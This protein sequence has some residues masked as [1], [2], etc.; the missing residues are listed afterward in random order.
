MPRVPSPE[1]D[2]V[3]YLCARRFPQSIE[4]P[5]YSYLGGS[6]S[7]Q[8]IESTRKWNLQIEEA[9]KKSE[10]HG[11]ELR[12]LDRSELIRLVSVEKNKEINEIL[13]KKEREEKKLS[14]NMPLFT[15]DIEHYAKLRY[16]TIDE[17]IALAYGR[18]PE[19]ATWAKVKPYT[20]ISEFAKTY[21]RA[22]QIAERA[23]GLKEI[24]Q[25]N[26]P[27]FFIS[28]AKRMVFPVPATLE[29]EV[30]K[31]GPIMDWQAYC[32]KLSEQNNELLSRIAELEGSNEPL[33][34]NEDAKHVESYPAELRAAIE[35]FEAVR[36]DEV[37]LAGRSPRKAL[38]A[39]LQQN[40]PEITANA[41]DRIATIANWQPSGGAPKT[42]G[43]IT[44][45]T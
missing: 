41:R 4:T 17:G 20:Q 28:W 15:Q 12:A 19:H 6:R 43:G 39:W 30:A 14:I 16:W 35:A 31:Y 32:Q 26:L 24:G 11:A 40:R 38:D 22:K 9:K 34:S 5:I 33:P 45:P 23:V 36:N 42:P 18:S 8:D 44:D 13:A 27:G 1:L 7:T 37:A 10:E 29:Q 3:G 25:T 2:P 21:E